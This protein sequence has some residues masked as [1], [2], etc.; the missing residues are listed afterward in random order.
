MW[1]ISRA[2][3]WLVWGWGDRGLGGMG[4]A[5][6]LGGIGSGTRCLRWG[7]A[8]Q[9]PYV[10]GRPPTLPTTPTWCNK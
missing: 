7:T 4:L 2:E 9:G 10:Q 8:Q 5:A 6:A 3:E 1:S